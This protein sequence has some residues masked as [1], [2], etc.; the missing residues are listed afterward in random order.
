MLFKH[1]SIKIMNMNRLSHLG[2]REIFGQEN[3]E[4][5]CKNIFVTSRFC[6]FSVLFFFRFLLLLLYR[7]RCLETYFSYIIQ[8]IG[9]YMFGNMF[10]RSHFIAMKVVRHA[11]SSA[12][13]YWTLRSNIKSI[14]IRAIVVRSLLESII[15]MKSQMWIH[16]TIAHIHKSHLCPNTNAIFF[17][18]YSFCSCDHWTLSSHMKTFWMA[19]SM[20][21][22]CEWSKLEIVEN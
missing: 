18:V 1:I 9:I 14:F 2:T 5:E 16:I 13:I 4:E 22:V 7:W 12:L 10:G 3:G 17:Y 21:M 11:N 15:T 19:F 8:A 6:L 20:A